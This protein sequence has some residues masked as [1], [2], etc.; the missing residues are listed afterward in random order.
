MDHLWTRRFAI[1]SGAAVVANAGLRGAAAFAQTPDLTSFDPAG[2]RPKVADRRFQSAVVEETITETSRKIGD[3]ALALLFANCFPNTLDT[4]VR[5]GTFE[6]RPDTAVITGDIAA[7]WL[8]DS[9]AQVWPYL[10]LAKKDPALRALLEGVIRRQT[11]CL[12]IDTYANAFMADLNAPPLSWSTK[13]LTTM[14]QG[15]GERKYELDSIC[16]PIRLAHGYWK[17]TGDIK[18][19][20][21]A[22]KQAMERVV[23][24]MQ[25]QQRKQ[26]DGPYKFQRTSP[27]STETLPAEG[28]GNPVKPVGLIASGFRP[29]D[30]ACI[31]PFLVPSNLFA[32]TSLRQM[33]ELANSVLHD[34]ALANRAEA[35]A[36]EVEAALKQYAVVPTTQ[37]T[38]WAYEV[39]GFGSQL[40]MD[41]ANV[42][43]LLGLPYLASSPDKALYA[44]TRAFVWS[45]RNP[46]FFKGSAGE[47]IGGPHEGRPMIWPMSQI[48]YALTSNNDAETHRSLAMLL[49]SAAGTN[50]IHESYNKD[51]IKKFTRPWFAWANTLFGELVLKVAAERPQLLR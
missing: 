34:A 8:R 51:D 11:R 29:S 18:P 22:W 13:D 41:D 25:E 44:R 4:T 24:T 32:V 3:P 46:W 7:M 38:I 36:S 47:G 37:G 30:D 17:Q 1:K 26:A 5:P 40:L 2:G 12:L 21:A 45:E 27:I 6:G 42:P 31:F 14:K 15:V 9:S 19:F 16:Y 20:D 48:V 10:P 39:D 49:A 23:Q 28:Y 50:F 33:A 43:S 35:L